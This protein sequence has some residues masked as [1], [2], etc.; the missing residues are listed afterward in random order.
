MTRQHRSQNECGS[1]RA[2]LRFWTV[3]P[4]PSAKRSEAASTGSTGGPPRQALRGE[5][6]ADIRY[7]MAFEHG[8]QASMAFYA[9]AASAKRS[10]AVSTGST[11]GP[12]RQ[13][14]RGSQA[15]SSDHLP[16]Q[17]EARNLNHA[18]ATC[19]LLGLLINR[20]GDRRNIAVRYSFY[21]FTLADRS[22]SACEPI[23]TQ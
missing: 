6:N 18:A 21:S 3:T 8:L 2:T 15:C 23:F 13:A 16:T 11:G 12:P 4:E 14:L 19:A 22:P 7:L 9:W 20:R 10:E 1:L 17:G 5:R